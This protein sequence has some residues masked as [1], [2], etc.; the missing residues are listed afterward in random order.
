MRDYIVSIVYY[1]PTEWIFA[2]VYRKIDVQR[3]YDLAQKKGYY[4]YTTELL[5][6]RKDLIAR[7]I[8]SF[9]NEF[10]QSYVLLENYYDQFIV[11]EILPQPYRITPFPGYENV[12]LSFERLKEI[13]L[14]EEVSWKTA[15]SNIKGV[16]LITDRKNGMHYVG[17]AYGNDAFWSRWQA[18]SITGHG[19][20]VDLMEILE[21]NGANYEVHFLFC[22][23]EIRSRITDDEEIIKRE[24]HWKDALMTR[25]FGYT[26][27]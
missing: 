16:Y 9:P 8:F 11:K 1:R 15:L 3:D 17:S 13:I 21:K 5:D 7:L 20:N 22:S 26:R 2:G 27:N 24:K 18:Y 12:I 4:R 10:R 14:S 23:L 19:N 25:E 6:T